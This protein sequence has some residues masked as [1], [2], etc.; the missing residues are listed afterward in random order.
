M[1]SWKNSVGGDRV[2]LNLNMTQTESCI[3][4]DFVGLIGKTNKIKSTDLN[5]FFS[6]G[7]RRRSVTWWCNN[8]KTYFNEI[9]LDKSPRRQHS[10]LYTR[11]KCFFSEIKIGHSLD[12]EKDYSKKKNEIRLN[13]AYWCESLLWLVVSFSREFLKD[14]S[15]FPFN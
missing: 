11:K 8:K 15:S 12:V 14:F 1:K 10:N 9:L 5:F 7:R 6:Q 2:K 13:F 3:R 4:V